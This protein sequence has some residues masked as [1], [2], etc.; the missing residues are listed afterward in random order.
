MKGH[1]DLNKQEK[2]I[3]NLLP[4]IYTCVNYIKE[5]NISDESLKQQFLQILYHIISICLNLVSLF[6]YSDFLT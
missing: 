5:N 6:L 1:E 4:S 2:V 3:S